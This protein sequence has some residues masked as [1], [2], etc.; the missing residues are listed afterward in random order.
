MGGGGSRS[1]KRLGRGEGEVLEGNW[2]E[3]GRGK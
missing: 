2:G 3:G 1:K